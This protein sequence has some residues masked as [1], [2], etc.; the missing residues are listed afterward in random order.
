[1]K[2]RSTAGLAAGL[3]AATL[4]PA[5]AA[6]EPVTVDLRIEGPTRT[7]FEGPVTTD[8][9]PFRFSGEASQHTCDGTAAIGGSSPT[10]VPTR[11]AAVAEAAERTP[12]SIA[13]TWHP[14]FGASFTSIAGETVAFDPAT[15]RF[16]AEYENGA[17]AQVGACA[18]DIRP[19]D[20]LLFAY[21]DGSEPLLALSGPATA[22]PGQ[23][24]TVRVTNQATGAPVDGAAV[25]GAVTGPDGTATVGPFATRG[26]HDLKA[27]KAGAIRSNRLRVCVTDGADGACGT[28]TTPTTAGGSP[29]AGADTTGPRAR[30]AGI[31]DGRRF[32][33]GPRLLRGTV[34]ADPSGLRAVKL[35]LSRQRGGACWYFSGSRERFLR[36][37]CGTRHA[38]RI[39]DSARWSYLLPARLP[40]GRYVLDVYAI[41][42]AGN[43]TAVD[44]GTSR[45][46]FLVR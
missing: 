29:A 2:L 18:D 21:G 6:A 1:M 43:R 27:T 41:D 8:V 31:R 19:G 12:F 3:V 10:P 32:A 14:Q 46:V 11:G 28:T 24:A 33:R 45:V 38:F 35:R 25:G 22:G 30:I 13:G 4:L 7:L 9:R 16:L 17:F 40:R 39:G 15:N 42:R 20:R 5:T 34:E 37:R 36:R 26:N 23:S 44:R